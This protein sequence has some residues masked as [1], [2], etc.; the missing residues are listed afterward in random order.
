M[1][2]AFQIFAVLVLVLFVVALIM[3]LKSWRI[4]T[5]IMVA[6]TFLS[7]MTLLVLSGLVLYTHSQWRMVI[8]GPPGMPEQGL[9]YRTA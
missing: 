8:E 9:R 4:H 6:L 1:T 7:A 3:G 2:F 5:V